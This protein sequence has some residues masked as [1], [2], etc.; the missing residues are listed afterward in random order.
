MTFSQFC[1]GA[2]FTL[3]ELDLADWF[4]IVTGHFE[5]ASSYG[6]ACVGSLT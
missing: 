2:H 3:V 1:R 5:G 6:I 4:R